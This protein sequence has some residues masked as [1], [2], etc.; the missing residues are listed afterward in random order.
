MNFTELLR[1]IVKS[2]AYASAG[3]GL[4]IGSAS[5]DLVDADLPTIVYL[6][7]AGVI[8]NAAKEYLKSLAEK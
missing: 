8:F 4:V 5:L 2:I 7:V 1:K 3:G 6:V